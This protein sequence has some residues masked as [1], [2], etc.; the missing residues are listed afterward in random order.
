MKEKT[1]ILKN[2]TQVTQD[3][4]MYEGKKYRVNPSV[5]IDIRL[6]LYFSSKK[7]ITVNCEEY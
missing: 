3:S 6:D 5:Q 4:F 2:I 7:T 1:F